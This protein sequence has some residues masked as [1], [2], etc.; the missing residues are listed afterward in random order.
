MKKHI[1]DR[2]I[3]N[4]LRNLSKL[5]NFHGIFMISFDWSIIVASIVLSEYYM[6]R[7]SLN[8]FLR[9]CPI[10]IF[11]YVVISSRINA[12]YEIFHAS[13]HRALADNVLLNNVLG[14]IF[15]GWPI[16]DSW[17]GYHQSHVVLH[18]N[19]L[20]NLKN[21]PDFQ[22]I[23][24]SGLYRRGIK[25]QDITK[26]LM[27]IPSPTRSIEYFKYLMKNK[28]LPSYESKTERLLRISY[29][30]SIIFLCWK[31]EYLHLLIFYWAIPYFTL[32]SWIA[33]ILEF[34]EH[35]PLLKIYDEDIKMSWNRKLTLLESFLFGNHNEDYHLVHHLWPRIPNWN[36][37]K[38]HEIMMQD[39]EY[40]KIHNM[41]SGLLHLIEKINQLTD[42]HSEF[43]EEENA[44]NIRT[45]GNS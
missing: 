22:G 21:D 30:S 32:A 19:N 16:L 40:N 11:A 37:P 17:T 2:A 41:P 34:T 6:D 7:N 24:D 36:L 39:E 44:E 45:E 29:W 1:F 20:G 12:L 26:F 18:H 14:T 4:E 3:V 15:S 5:D 8:S 27:T 25:S 23:V 10:Y 9:T 33:D 31:Y 43:F 38:A 13:T 35:Y 28:I 42:I